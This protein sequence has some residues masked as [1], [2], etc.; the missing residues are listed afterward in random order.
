MGDIRA[1]LRDAFAGAISSVLSIA[2]C[3]SYA[4]LIFSGPLAPWL[5]YG[6]AVAFLSSALGA[7]TVALRSSFAFGIGGPDTSTSAVV[8]TLM[9]VTAARLAS[10]GNAH[11]LPAALIVMALATVLTGAILSL[12]GLTRAGRAI[13]FVPYP[14]IGGFLG[15]TGALMILGAMQVITGQKV[16]WA[17][18]AVLLNHSDMA[19]IAAGVAVA[20]V[21]ELLLARSRNALIMPS[22]LLAAILGTHL[23]LYFLHEPLGVAQSAGWVFRPAPAAALH[24]PLDPAKIAIFPWK[25][26]PVI[27]GE[28]FAV[29]FVTTMSVLLNASGIEI[30][31]KQEADIE[32]ELR[33]VGLANLLCGMLGGF[34]SCLALAR[35]SLARAAGATGRLAGLT[36]A[37]ISAVMLVV[38]PVFLGYVPK[39]ALGGLLLFTGGRLFARWL[40]TAAR[41]ILP[42]EYASLLVIA[43]MIIAWGYI[44]G[45]A[46]GTM[47]GCLTF[48]FSASRVNAIKFSFD[49]TEYRSS[50]DRS[51]QEL[52]LL[53]DHGREIQG[54]ALQSY[55][56][57][58]SAN[59]LYMRVKALLAERQ[60]CRFLLFDFRLVTGLD[61]AAIYSFSQIRDACEERGACIILVNLAP[62]L[63]RVLRVGRFLDGG[64]MVAGSLDKALEHCEE[65]VIAAHRKPVNEAHSLRAWLTQA[66][67]SSD[68]A[69][70]LAENC[71]RRDVVQGDVIARQ[72]QAARSMHFILEGRVGVFV[73]QDDGREIRVRS[74][75][76]QTTIGEMGL[77][78]H[79]PRSGTLKAEAASI[80]YELPLDALERIRCENPT[81]GQ[82]LLSYVTEVMAERLG[83]AN[84]VIGVLQR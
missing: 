32:R 10:S 29:V 5:S 72:G 77:I 78:A 70:M 48:A 34:V 23:A 16:S 68:L 60:E 21:L 25:I 51:P 75:G 12:L 84:R 26:L 44:A 62:D 56:F 6:V 36:L 43:V 9:A 41:Q 80:L 7:A 42:L 11:L 31:T 67:N 82:A 65:E 33:A 38:D 14:V 28:L 71:M 45:I 15:A 17:H 73:M 24:L 66:L 47:I 40:I 52:A 20:I 35:T 4:A 2:Y 3:L 63:E 27:S 13:R 49:N 79:K 83:F 59:R 30:A 64:V 76:P 58:G 74:L 8:A 19:K 61:S 57:F 37:A 54:M 55:L 53:A 1:S 46:I 50:L 18:L 39:F 22:V 81:L 69:G